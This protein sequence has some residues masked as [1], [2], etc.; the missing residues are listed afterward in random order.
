MAKA[1]SSVSSPTKSLKKVALS[2]KKSATTDAFHNTTRL[3][4]E[5]FDKL[6][7]NPHQNLDCSTLDLDKLSVTESETV[8]TAADSLFERCDENGEIDRNRCTLIKRI[9]P[10]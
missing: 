2:L 3:I 10:C 8:T 5:I 6:Q 4:G 1:I 7:P 9:A